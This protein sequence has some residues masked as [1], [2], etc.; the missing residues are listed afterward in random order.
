[1]SVEPYQPIACSQYDLY[2]IAIMRNQWVELVWWDEPGVVH[3]AR[4]KPVGLQ[5]REGQ[6]F[7]LL[8]RDPSCRI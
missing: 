2:E 1:M 3:Q 5:T 6:E 8:Q 4:L 7:L